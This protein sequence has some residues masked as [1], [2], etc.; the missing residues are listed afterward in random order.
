MILKIKTICRDKNANRIDEV[1]RS[2]ARKDH[3]RD[4][5]NTHESIENND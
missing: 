4:M 3:G 2:P 5:Y 1:M